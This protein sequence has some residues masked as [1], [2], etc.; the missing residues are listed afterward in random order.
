MFSPS[1][2][3]FFWVYFSWWFIYLFEA[4]PQVASPRTLVKIIKHMLTK[5]AWGR[6][7]QGWEFGLDYTDKDSTGLFGIHTIF[8]LSSYSYSASSYPGKQGRRKWNKP[9]ATSA[10]NH[11]TQ[12]KWRLFHEPEVSPEPVSGRILWWIPLQNY[13]MWSL[14]S[15]QTTAFSSPVARQH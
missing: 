12:G 13:V 8:D 9:T 6:V 7:Y 5:C 3:V 4:Y 2:D 1:G 10:T 14:T 11:L 15:P